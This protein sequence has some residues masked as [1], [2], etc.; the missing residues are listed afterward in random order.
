MKIP[1]VMKMK[2]I[3]LY[4]WQLPQ[5]LLGLL[6]IRVLGAEEAFNLSDG[7][8]YW[9]YKPTGRFGGFISGVSLG[10]YIIL[11]T[12]NVNTVRHEY[13]HSRQSAVFGPFYLL[14]VGLPSAI[15][16]LLDRML[17]KKWPVEKRLRWYYSRWP[18]KQA[19]RLGGVNREY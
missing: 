12:R 6:L 9:L 14:L 16:N 8:A 3:L 18:E 19:D 11:K 5:R 1:G 13:G 7:I 15:G 4:A 17:H 10:G 2:E